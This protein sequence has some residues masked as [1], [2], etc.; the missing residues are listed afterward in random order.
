[1]ADRG[2]DVEAL[3]G[4]LSQPQREKILQK[5]KKK[6]INILVATDVA[7]RGIDIND[8]THVINYAIPQDADAY[9]HRI[10]R[11]GRAGKEGTAITF[12]TPEEYRKL[13]YI[14]RATKTDIRKEKLPKIHEVLDFKKSKIQAEI[15]KLA[16][17]DLSLEYINLAQQLLTQNSSEKVIAAV[18]KYTF[19][20]ELNPKNYNEIRDTY[21]QIKGKT[22]LFVA[23]G[24]KD[25]MSKRKLVEFIKNKAGVQDRNIDDVQVFDNYSFITVPFKEAEKILFHFKQ[26]KNG[27]RSVVE[28]A[29][30]DKSRGR[31]A[32]LSAKRKKK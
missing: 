4:D 22:R 7:A 23:K 24:K 5:F 25:D 19:Q 16:Q 27:Q 13:M 11:T 18:L 14:Q 32:F 3:H 31:P 30:K 6:R 9:V 20:N 17:S 26:K 2:Y 8:L 1:M 29:A 15:G 28:L 21:P 10:G 12:I